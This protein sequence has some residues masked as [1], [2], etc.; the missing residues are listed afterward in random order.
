MT[1]LHIPF[2]EKLKLIPEVFGI[3]VN[4]EPQYVVVLSDGDFEVR[5]YPKQLVVK[6]SMKGTSFDYFKQTAFEKLAN[7]IFTGN[8]NKQS[9]PMTS[10][11]LQEHGDGQSISMH[12]HFMEE[13]NDEG[14]WTMS[15]ILPH[16]I[17]KEN[18][19]APLDN[20]IRLEEIDPQL[21][22]CTT[23]S[24]NNNGENIKKHERKLAQWLTTRPDIQ[25][26]GKYFVAQYDAP[27][28]IPFLKKNEIHVRVIN[29]H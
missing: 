16:E 23:Y 13:P 3:R 17:T 7:Y 4:E 22:A 27:F 12:S 26:Q 15:F 8:K 28:V 1:D 9:I 14:G 25:I 24:G 6:F 2:K 19:P 5:R 10:P 18:A 11:V 29:M 21:M 20:S